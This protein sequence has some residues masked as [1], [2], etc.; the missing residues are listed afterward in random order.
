MSA[1]RWYRQPQPC[2][3]QWISLQATRLPLQS[4]PFNA[5]TGLEKS[6]CVPLCASRELAS[7]L[8]SSQ[9]TTI[10]LTNHG[11]GG[12]VGRGRGVGVGR[13]GTVTVAVGVG[14]GECAVAVAVAVADAAGVAVGLGVGVAHVVG[15]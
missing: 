15:M 12:G 1:T 8:A 14:V 9:V 11:R 2:R 10:A 4:Q 5:S 6:G 13:G 7:C 3:L